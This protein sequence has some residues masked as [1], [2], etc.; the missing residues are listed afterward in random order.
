MTITVEKTVMYQKFYIIRLGITV[1]K[2]RSLI[3]VNNI[4]V[5]KDSLYIVSVGLGFGLAGFLLYIVVVNVREGDF[6]CGD[7]V[8][9]PVQFIARAGHTEK[10]RVLF[11]NFSKQIHNNYF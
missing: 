5:N 4:K 11:F 1:K 2:R 10:R 7:L 8:T 6:T 9:D 3:T